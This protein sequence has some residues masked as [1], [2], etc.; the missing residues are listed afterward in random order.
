MSCYNLEHIID[1]CLS[2]K[3]T[4]FGISKELYYE[5]WDAMNRWIDSRI[6]KRKGA[7]IPL[8]GTL[9]WETVADNTKRPIFL[10]NDAF[11]KLHRVKRPR[12]FTDPVIASV[13]ELNYSQISIKYSTTLTKDMVFVGVR[14]IVKKIGDFVDRMYEFELPFSIGTLRCK[15]RKVKFDF[16]LARLTEVCSYC[17]LFIYI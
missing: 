3:G 16:N 15:E 11:V 12:Q 2:D 13:D 4:R 7:S 1:E 8:L 10:L 17:I 14:D 9:G 5:V 6:A